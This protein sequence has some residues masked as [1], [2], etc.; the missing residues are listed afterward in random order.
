MDWPQRVLKSHTTI[1]AA[2]PDRP[3]QPW[4]CPK[5]R[6]RTSGLALGTTRM[7]PPI[8]RQAVGFRG[9]LRPRNRAAPGGRAAQLRRRP[10]NRMAS[11]TRLVGVG[12]GG[13]RPPDGRAPASRVGRT[14]RG[15]LGGRTG[16][17]APMGSAVMTNG[18][19]A[20]VIAGMREEW[21]SSA[22]DPRESQRGRH[23]LVPR[24]PTA[25][26]TWVGARDR[27]PPRR[28]PPFNSNP[29]PDPPPPSTIWLNGR[30]LAA[31]SPC[32]SPSSTT[33]DRGP[34]TAATARV[35]LTRPTP[36][37]GPEE[38]TALG[39]RRL[40]AAPAARRGRSRSADL[41]ATGHDVAAAAASPRRS[42]SS[43]ATSPN[44][45]SD[46]QRPPHYRGAPRRR[47]AG[48]RL[49]LDADSPTDGACTARDACQRRHVGTRRRAHG[50]PA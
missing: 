50:D 18:E 37:A 8:L 41:A 15:E 40:P 14:A 7:L 39:P 10:W 25:T 46:R 21:P 3:Q 16:A 11:A 38:R 23:R 22:S 26:A 43:A 49:G 20:V 36:K 4:R 42:P 31:P 33:Q 34:A 28:R 19:L 32:V 27:A 5:N 17:S 35:R 29:P 9:G 2:P 24:P 1:V 44:R 45:P 47:G 30:A 12:R 6:S 48:V 13:A